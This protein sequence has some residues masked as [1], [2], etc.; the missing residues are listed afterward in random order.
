MSIIL[1]DGNIV[2]GKEVS[3]LNRDEVEYPQLMRLQLD[4]DFRVLSL[5]AMNVS[6]NAA[7]NSSESPT[8]KGQY[9]ITFNTY[10]QQDV[11]TITPVFP[12]LPELEQYANE[13]IVDILNKLV[14]DSLED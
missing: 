3:F 12:S 6:A 7:N 11:P 2:C 5:T 10:R 14:V 1:Q 4:F 8:P 13:N 9:L